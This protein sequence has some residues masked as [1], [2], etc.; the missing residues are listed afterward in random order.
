[1]QVRFVDM[2]NDLVGTGGEA[3]PNGQN[4]GRFRVV[5]DVGDATRTVNYMV[6]MSADAAG[7]PAG[8]QVW[9]TTPNGYWPLGIER[10]GR[11]LNP[12]DHDIADQ[13][14]RKVSYDVYANDS[15]WFKDGNHFLVLVRFTDGGEVSG[16]TRIGGGS[17]ADPGTTFASRWEEMT[18]TWRG[19]WQL[20]Y[21]RQVCIHE[22]DCSC[23]GYDFCGE[24]ADGTIVFWWRDG[25]AKPAS[26]IRCHSKPHP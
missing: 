17:A 14:W 24:H 7:K 2:N 10:E 13:V 20:D 4:D 19:N 8:G 5:L 1:M 21:E 3:S 11:R 25:C 12:R 9:D 23:H 26:M 16:L 18:G 15:G 6:L 22:K